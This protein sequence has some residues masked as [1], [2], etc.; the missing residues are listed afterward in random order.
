MDREARSRFWRWTVLWRD[1]SDRFRDPPEHP[2]FIFYFLFL[3]LGLGAAGTWVELFKYWRSTNASE[4]LDGLITSLVT[5]FFALIGTSCTQ[6]II[7][8]TESK[9][10]KTLAQGI[11]ITSM[12]VV[13]LATAGI[14]KGVSAA[15][16]WGFGSAIALAVWWIA[17]AKTPGLRDPDAPTGGSLKKDL[18]GNLSGYTTE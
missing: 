18:P 1:I 15:W 2:T 4:P 11:L 9:A 12:L 8:D 7:D 5:F 16:A 10:L 17:N 6:I 13:I 3:V 14:G